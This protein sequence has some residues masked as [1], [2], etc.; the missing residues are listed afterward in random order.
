MNKKYLKM[1]YLK[2]SLLLIIPVILA[3]CKEKSTNSM[4]SQIEQ[5]I[6]FSAKQLSLLLEDARLE[7]NIPRTLT[8][9]GDMHWIREDFDWT[10]GFYPG[11]SW[12]LYELTKQ[13]KWK[14]AAEEFQNIFE[15]HKNYTQYHDLGFVFNC[16]YGNGYRLTGNE[17]FKDVLVTAGNS[18]ITRFDPKVGCIKSWDVEKGWQST[19][20]WKYPVI[21]DNMMNLEMLF[22]LSKITDDQKY[23]D[24]AISHADTTLKNH[25]RDDYSSYHVIDYDPETGA[26]R[27]RNTAQGYAHESAWARGQAWAV[28]GY[29]VCYRYTRDERYLEHAK[30]IAQFIINYPGTPKDGIP[31]WDYNAPNIPNEPR[32]VSAAAVTASAL[33]ELD[34]YTKQSYLPAINKIMKSIATPEYTAKLGENKHFILKHSVGS[35]PHNHEIDVPL[36]YADYYYLEALVRYKNMMKN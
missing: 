27:N 32:D 36:N 3:S 2:F 13:D 18:L 10:E 15:E 19:R 1:K 29:T 11:S 8:K 28:Y 25:F 16:S 33:I 14:V 26:V 30:K 17:A 22:E 24:I 23:A 12:Y 7:K 6:D 35:I 4:Q 21:I 20:G 34:G 9:E 5:Q 31:Y